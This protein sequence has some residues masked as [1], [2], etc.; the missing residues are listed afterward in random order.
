MAVDKRQIRRCLRL[1]RMA[2]ERRLGTIIILVLRSLLFLRH[3]MRTGGGIGEGPPLPAPPSL[4][5][6]L[7]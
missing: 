1:G 6:C 4:A 3:G 7:A 5:R 2:R